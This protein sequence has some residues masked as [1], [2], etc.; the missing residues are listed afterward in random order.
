MIWRTTICHMG[1]EFSEDDED[2]SRI[3]ALFD[4]APKGCTAPRAP[5]TT[6][7]PEQAA[8][9]EELFAR[10]RVE[11]WGALEASR[12]NAD[13]TCTMDPACPFISGCE[14]AE[15]AHVSGGGSPAT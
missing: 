4:A 7:T 13:D 3:F 2:P 9:L 10:N 11:D 5:L 12:C 15:A 14:T 8:H 1:I 6:P